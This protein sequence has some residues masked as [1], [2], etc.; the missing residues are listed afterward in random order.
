[1]VNNPVNICQSATGL[2]DMPQTTRL[3]QRRF[4]LMLA[5]VEHAHFNAAAKRA[6][7][8]LSNWMRSRLKIVAQVEA[9]EAGA[10]EPAFEVTVAL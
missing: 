5:P 4:I 2:W 1:V 9:E 3:R 7:T 6:N 10:P 8:N